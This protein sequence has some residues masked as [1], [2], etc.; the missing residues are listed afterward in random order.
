MAKR[1]WFSIQSKAKTETAEAVAEISLHDE[2]GFWG[3]TAK[4]FI[5]QFQAIPADTK[6][7]KLSINSPGGAVFDGLAMYNAMANSDKDIEV[8]VLGIAASAASL[9]AMAGSSI[10]MPENTY[11]MVH[12]PW[13][14]SVGNAAD[15]RDTADILDKIGAG[16]TTT[17]AKR[18]GLSPEKVNELLAKDTWMTAAQ[19]KELGFADEVMPAKKVKAAFDL[20]NLPDALKAAFAS[21]AD[22]DPDD[23]TDPADDDNALKASTV[24][25]A[26]KAAGFEAYAGQWALDESIAD[27]HALT[28]RIALAKET[29]ALCALCKKPEAAALFIKANSPLKEVRAKLLDSQA[30]AD[31]SQSIDTAL[32]IVPP[33]SGN[34][35][36]PA[37]ALDVGAQIWANRNKQFLRS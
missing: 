16:L 12:N 22:P 18:T 19:A 23:E 10:R 7:V 8:T 14:V 17:Y 28:A 26:A 21:A 30:S 20:D 6:K 2:I 13:G 15:M 25:I 31:E 1:T 5:S 33:N 24:E 36:Q 3:I 4:D 29:T 35:V 27:E 37:A 34:G 11:M 32:K 9:V